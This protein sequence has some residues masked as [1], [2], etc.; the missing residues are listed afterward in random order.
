M[1][2]QISM[3]PVVAQSLNTNMVTGC[4]Q[5]PGHLCGLWWQHG[6]LDTNT[7]S[8]C[9]RTM[10]PGH[11][12]PGVSPGHSNQHDPHGNVAIGH[13]HDHKWWPGLQ[14]SSWPPMVT[15]A[16]DINS[17]SVC[18]FR[19]SDQDL[20]L[21]C[22]SGLDIIMNPGGKPAIHVGLFLNTLKSSLQTC[23]SPQLMNGSTSL[24][25]P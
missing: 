24:P 16:T 18:C 4:S 25:S 9:G 7:V 19:T 23:L 10:D 22:S 13:Q 12:G 1:V 2:T 21:G 8:T 20:A 6:P 11:Y 17:G 3:A 5:D 15:R 14:A